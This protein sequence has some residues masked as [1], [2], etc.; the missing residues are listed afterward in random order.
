MLRR[1]SAVL[2]VLMVVGAGAA[3]ASRVLGVRM[4][5]E[6][7]DSMRPV[8]HT[9]DLVLSRDIL[10]EQART[11][12]IVTF[13]DPELP[14]R[15]VT[16]RVEEV[17]RDGEFLIFTTRGDANPGTE[18]WTVLAGT[19][20]GR[21][22]HVLPDLGLIVAPLREPLTAAVMNGVRVTLLVLVA[23]RRRRSPASPSP[24]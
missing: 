2:M 24:R 19:T 20:I 5:V 18:Q 3:S 13:P 22:V 12:D 11:G 14:A 16:H 15:T 10:V 9:G 17:R 23:V 21:T 1:L 7:S 8:I 4:L 6:H